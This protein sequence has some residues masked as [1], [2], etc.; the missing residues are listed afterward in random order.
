MF[1]INLF[2]IAAA[3]GIGVEIYNYTKDKKI[4][5]EAN[6]R[7]KAA[8]WQ[9]QQ[10]LTKKLIAEHNLRQLEK[11]TLSQPGRKLNPSI[12]GIEMKIRYYS[13]SRGE[14]VEKELLAYGLGRY[15]NRYYVIAHSY[16][17]NERRT[18]KVAKFRSCINL[19]T[20]K[21]ITSIKNFLLDY[22]PNVEDLTGE[23]NAIKAE[24]ERR[25]GFY[26]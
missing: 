10:A 16:E 8:E 20:G 15:E 13:E 4:K 12:G 11:P 1:F 21:K 23:F 22:N 25:N 26:N 7:I 3:I 9:A 17:D 19:E 18:Y 14:M 2:I 24:R 5:A 6:A